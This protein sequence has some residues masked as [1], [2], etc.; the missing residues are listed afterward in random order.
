MQ[1][2]LS[3]LGTD[4]R[5]QVAWAPDGRASTVQDV[6]VVA[7]FQMV[8]RTCEAADA[9]LEAAGPLATAQQ[10]PMPTYSSCFRF[11]YTF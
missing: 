6:G 11:S 4:G 7:E 2:T 9:L 5:E 8:E 1:H 3:V 10:F